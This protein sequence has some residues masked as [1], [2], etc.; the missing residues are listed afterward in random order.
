MRCEMRE[1]RGERREA[2]GERTGERMS[3]ERSARGRGTITSLIDAF[4]CRC[5]GAR[6]EGL[7]DRPA[8]ASTARANLDGGGGQNDG[9]NG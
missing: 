9:E 6:A 8:A 7:P 5:R 4:G 1:A 2:R 3:T